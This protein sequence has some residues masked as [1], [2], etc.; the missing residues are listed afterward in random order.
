MTDLVPSGDQIDR[1]TLERIIRR[2]AELQAAE[3]EIGD[4]LTEQ[5]VLELGKEVG[6]PNRYVRQAML[7][8]RSRLGASEELGFLTRWVGPRRIAAQRTL[9]GDEPK[10]TRALDYWMT[11]GELLTVK[12]R[13]KHGTSWEARRDFLA[14]I[15]RSLGFGGR[16]YVLS[17]AQEVIGEV[18]QLE[19]G[20][21][22]ATL[23][24]DLSNTRREYV[25]GGISVIGA[26]GVVTAVGIALGFAIPVA[27]IPAAVGIVA[28]AAVAASRRRVVEQAQ[29]A[30]EQV[31]DRLEHGEIDP[32][33]KTGGAALRDQLSRALRDG[34]RRHLGA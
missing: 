23:S 24:A 17:R 27:A 14:A 5:Q 2:A 16:R 7:E 29:V 15:K 25:G 28:G 22:L 3:H 10:I 32:D 1:Q 13:F 11:E 21:S 9:P 8:E 31:L 6:L 26:G 4:Q 30:L 20:W 34:V 19:A 33:Q 12:R 18:T